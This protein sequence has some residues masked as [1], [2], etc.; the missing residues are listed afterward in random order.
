MISGCSETLGRPRRACTIF[1]VGFVE[2]E[3][4]VLQ[5]P[6][7]V[8]VFKWQTSTEPLASM[9]PLLDGMHPRWMVFLPSIVRLE[10]F[11]LGT[12]RDIPHVP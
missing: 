2:V 4:C 3:G 6:V 9:V 1:L 12:D 11:I 7:H 8:V 10:A 5:L